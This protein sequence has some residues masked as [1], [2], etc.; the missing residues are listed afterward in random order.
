[1]GKIKNAHTLDAAPATAEREAMTT[2]PV[3]IGTQIKQLAGLLETSDLTDWAC[4]DKHGGEFGPTE[5]LY[6]LPE[7][8]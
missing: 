5:F 7:G 2:R 4:R 1:M 8:L 6:T 3:S